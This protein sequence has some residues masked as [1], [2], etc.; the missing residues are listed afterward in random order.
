[1]TMTLA[2]S[3]VSVMAQGCFSK[4]VTRDE[5]D[6]LSGRVDKL[7]QTVYPKPDEPVGGAGL[8]PVTAPGETAPLDP[9]FAAAFGLPPTSVNPVV[10]PAASSKEKPVAFAV[11]STERRQYNQARSLLNQK[12][13]AQAAG[14][15]SD[16]LKAYP[17][18]VLAPNAR[19]W[20]GEC[21]Y[22]VGDY[23][24]ALLEFKQGYNDFPLSN[25]APDFLL[26]MS[27]CQSY[28]GDGPGAMESM[29][30]LLTNFPD[31]DSALLVKSGRSRFSGL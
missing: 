21:R 9:A 25:K 13:Y 27:Y 16:Q 1:M 11:A 19:Y 8:S 12:K 14:A 4:K 17:G 3:L 28:L 26:K 10:A 23:S 30:L 18:G 31:S 29:R 7:E 24:A 20:L 2:L 22:A 5:F 15:F 6:G